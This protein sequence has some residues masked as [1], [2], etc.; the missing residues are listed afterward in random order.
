[1]FLSKIAKQSQ[2]LS[3]ITASFAVANESSFLDMVRE[4]IDKA[5]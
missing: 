3:R 5:G 4:Y 2:L 1:M